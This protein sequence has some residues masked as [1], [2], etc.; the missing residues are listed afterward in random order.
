MALAAVALVAC[1]S[2]EDEPLGDDV[3][4]AAVE[5]PDEPV[6]D[7]GKPDARAKPPA[8]DAGKPDGGAVDP[9]CARADWGAARTFE[10]AHGAFPDSGHPDVAVYVPKH[11]DPCKPQG[12][13]VFFHGF[14]NCVANVIGSEP[15]VCTEGQP[16]RSA[17]GLIDDLEATNANAVLIA[18]EL[19]YDQATGAPGALANDNGM[20]SL[21]DELYTEQLSPWF[22]HDVKVTDLDRVVLTSHSGGYTALARALDSGG[23]PNVTDAV[24]FDSLYGEMAAYEDFTLGQLERFDV[25]AAEPLRFGIVY[26]S[27]GGTDDDSRALAHEIQSALETEDREDAL[28]F[29]DTTD[30]LDVGAYATPIVIKHSGLSHDGV[31]P[32]YFGLFVAA[33]GF[34][35]RGE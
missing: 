34:P 8:P 21:L 14:K 15:T 13:V 1:G 26:T 17:L 25:N 11:F 6:L 32:Y 31:V 28:L 2:P 29:D 33:A 5:D 35:I 27:G 12:A 7:A 30:T 16:A 3:A 22:E 23:L 18:V 9:G 24:L 19:K 10:L 4:D 20:L